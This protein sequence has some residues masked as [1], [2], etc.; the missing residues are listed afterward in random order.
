VTPR[1]GIV[2]IV[3]G[4]ALCLV[5]LVGGFVF[6][7]DGAPSAEP[8]TTEATSTTSTTEDPADLV[9]QAAV[10]GFY[11]L[12]QTAVQTGDADTLYARLHPAVLDLY[13]ADQCRAFIDAGF[14]NPDLTF[15]VVSVGPLEPWVWE[16]DGRTVDVG[17]A[18]ALQLVQRTL[19]NPDP[20][21]QE[22]HVAL[23]DG[24]IRWFTDCG[25]P[26]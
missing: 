15:E 14:D 20:A 3:A 11:D 25:D 16:R 17:D 24:E 26:L 23:V 6:A 1:H 4:A 21:P 9:D 19:A 22:A 8:T 13:G 10:E 12:F 18:V 5:G 7:D 2:L